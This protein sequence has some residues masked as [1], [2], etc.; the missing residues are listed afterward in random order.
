MQQNFSSLGLSDKNNN[1]IYNNKKWYL[2]DWQLG[3]KRFEKILKCYAIAEQSHR[4]VF[5][6]FGYKHLTPGE[7]ETYF[8]LK[9]LALLNE[10]T[11]QGYYCQ[12]SLDYLAEVLNTTIDCQSRRIKKL[13][14]SGLLVIQK[15]TS[16]GT[17]PNTY[18]P[19]RWALPDS[20]LLSTLI[21]LIRR[22]RIFTLNYEYDKSETTQEARVK[23]IE[24]VRHIL[25]KIPR[26][27]EHV[28]TSIKND[29]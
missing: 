22:K 14:Q 1:F 19:I 4:D 23:I 11:K 25:K 5:L 2:I 18:I 16:N 21:I 26:F 28:S 24:E 15:R 20:S 17:I 8:I 9:D 12:I 13:K 3:L 7:K 29:L 10:K 27:K 6:M